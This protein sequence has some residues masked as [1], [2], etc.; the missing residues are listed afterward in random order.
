MVSR[1]IIDVSEGV[2][3]KYVAINGKS[4][5]LF[6]LCTVHFVLNIYTEHH[7]SFIYK[8]DTSVVFALWLYEVISS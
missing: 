7:N 6:I 1:L 8:T 5:Y 4:K 2:V 3:D